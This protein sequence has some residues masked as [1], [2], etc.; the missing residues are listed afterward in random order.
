MSAIPSTSLDVSP[1]APRR[2]VVGR[3]VTRQLVVM[4]AVKLAKRPMT[5]VS[6]LLLAG[7]LAGVFVLGYTSAH[8]TGIDAAARA[9]R[10]AD[11]TLPKGIDSAFDVLG[12]IGP[13]VLAVF[14]ALMIGSEFGWGTIR[15]MASTGASR[16][17]LLLA[18]MLVLAGA[19]A[20]FLLMAA[21]AGA[22][23]S[24]AVTLFDGRHISAGTFDAHWFGQLA[25][26]LARTELVWFTIVMLA[27]A[28][29][30]VFRSVAAGVAVGIGWM[31]LERVLLAFLITLGRLGD[32]VSQ[33]LLVVNVNGLLRYNGTLPHAVDPG[34]PAEWRTIAILGCYML[35]LLA[36]ALV[37]FQ[38]R[39]I[40]TGGS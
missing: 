10:I 4:E 5:W 32:R 7:G 24:L 31:V 20:L 25:L 6:L 3:P 16:S 21:L 36:V 14:A 27:F 18:K 29:A 19:S 8:T 2:Y 39:D 17:K 11:L 30:T 23:A 37:V 38:R 13:I 26:S 1:V 9:G 22:L 15:T 12:Q 40:T 28:V 35:V 34:T 33:G